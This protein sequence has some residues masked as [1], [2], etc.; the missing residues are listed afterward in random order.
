[1]RNLLRA[2]R[3][4]SYQGWTPAEL[5]AMLGRPRKRDTVEGDGTYVEYI[6]TGEGLPHGWSED[7]IDGFPYPPTK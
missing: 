7:P 2:R 5:D 3:I 1:M 6:D 4:R